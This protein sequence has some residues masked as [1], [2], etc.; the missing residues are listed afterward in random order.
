MGRKTQI[1][2]VGASFAVII[3]SLTGYFLWPTRSD[4]PAENRVSRSI[5]PKSGFTFFDIDAETRLDDA[6]RDALESRLGSDAIA[7]RMPFNID[8]NYRGFLK[9]HFPNLH[10]INQDLNAPFGERREHNTVKLM[11]R[12]ARRKQVPFEYVELVFSNF[13][14]RPLLFQIQPAGVGPAILETLKEK[15]GPPRSI[16]WGGGEAET[17]WWE[18]ETDLLFATI[19]PDRFGNPEYRFNIIFT[20]NIEDMILSEKTEAERREAKRR[21]AGENAF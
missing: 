5:N 9:E 7:Y 4:E 15:Y 17:L 2:I 14:K 8:L 18:Y 12:R 19:A 6:L 16:S 20:R 10:R 3:L 11:Y 1:W 13:N 21:K